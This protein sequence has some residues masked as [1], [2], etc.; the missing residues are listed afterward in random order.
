MCQGEGKAHL[1]R[2]VKV[3][4]R[5]VG[6]EPSSE[7]ALGPRQAQPCP[8]CSA[9]GTHFTNGALRARSWSRFS[10]DEIQMSNLKHS[11]R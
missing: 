2:G 1:Q 9:L 6:A 8:P 5:W 4:E 10:M 3:G 11:S 7:P